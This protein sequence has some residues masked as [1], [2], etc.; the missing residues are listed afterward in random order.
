MPFF[1]QLAVFA[2]T[3]ALAL[4]DG[5]A[6]AD[7]FLHNPRG[8][9]NRGCETT[10]TV[11]NSN[12]LFNAQNNAAGGYACPRAW[13]FACWAK[14][15][16]LN[17][18]ASRNACNE[19]NGSGLN[20][21]LPEA[22]ADDDGVLAASGTRT[23]RLYFHANSTLE[24]LMTTSNGCGGGVDCD[25]VIQY[26]CEDTLSDDCGSPGTGQVCGPR[27]GAPI[28]NSNRDFGTTAYTPVDAILLG[29]QNVGR[30]YRDQS[31]VASI[32]AS[33][34][35]NAQSDP[36]FG[37][38]ETLAQFTRCM[39]RERNRGL[40]TADRVPSGSSALFTR[41]NFNG[42][43]YGLECNE[44]RDYFP[45]WA[46]APW[47]DVAVI[48]SRPSVRCPEVAAASQNV[49]D[50]WDCV[51]PTCTALGQVSPSSSLACASAGGV[52]TKF[53]ARGDP[54]PECVAAPVLPE[55]TAAQ[56]TYR[57]SIPATARGNTC[58]IRVRYNV[59]TKD[60]FSGVLSG[61]PVDQ[62]ADFALNGA[63]S[64]LKDRQW[65]ERGSY[66][67]FAD[68]PSGVQLGLATNTAQMGRVFQ[69]RSWSFSIVAPPSN[70]SCAGKRVLNLNTIGKRGNVVQV[71][72]SLTY[73]Y[74]PPALRV[75]RATDCVHVQWTGSDYNPAQNANNAVGGPPDPRNLNDGRAD[76]FNLVQVAC[77]G[78]NYP[79]STLNESSFSVFV[80]DAGTIRRFAFLDQPWR[81]PTLCWNASVLIALSA[82]ARNAPSD[83]KYLSTSGI[84]S[85]GMAQSDSQNYL[86]DADDRMRYFRNCA[87][88]SGAATPYFDA[89][90][91][92]P[93]Q[94][95][96]HYVTDTRNS[97][98]GNRRVIGTVVVVDSGI[99]GEVAA[100]PAPGPGNGTRNGTTVPSGHVRKRG[101]ASVVS[102]FVLL[103]SMSL[104]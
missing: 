14:D 70:G 4:L 11:V 13:P 26:A 68:L 43:Q 48:T 27:D 1:A 2:A 93:G 20:D 18:Q 99:Q 76:R 69:D 45:Y 100:T 75:D 73:G 54:P 6:T 30:N 102:L 92:V 71:Y 49:A 42:D 46:D 16:D 95:G 29:P 25:V 78:C 61:L 103:T 22:V 50:K 38:H 83:P 39:H 33:T 34:D 51:C 53:P 40:F 58:M 79:M 17:D 89:G 91:L 101:V 60:G 80:A 63:S 55:N 23:P 47:R 9:N 31:S 15:Y 97:V 82:D 57:W 66:V 62:F 88:L 65:S 67:S 28:T 44:E 98:M 19:Q 41:Q 86:D 96:T 81:D 5:R 59:T 24:L 74:Y 104:K 36:R 32:P 72:P 56:L 90:L 8:S 10:P 52:W 37:R 84:N 12:R 77:Q 94:V 7:I 35:H 21:T 64:P 87:K 85:Y 3:L